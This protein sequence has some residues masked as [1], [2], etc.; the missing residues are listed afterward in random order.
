MTLKNPTDRFADMLR[1]AVIDGGLPPHQTPTP[2]PIDMTPWQ[3][4]SLLQKT[5]RRG[6][7]GFALQAAAS[8]LHLDPDR[9]WRRAGIIAFEDIG[10]ADL[11]TVGMVTAALA[12]KRVRHSLGGEW[13]VA[14]TITQ[15]MAKARKNRAA[16]DLLCLLDSW[17][18]LNDN[19]QR[20]APLLISRLRLIVLTTEL[21]PLRALAL[22]MIIADRRLDPPRRGSTDIA[23][24]ILDELGVAP[25]TLAIAREGYRRTGEVLA[26]L[27]ALLSLENG[28]KDNLHH[29]QMPPASMIGGLP[30][31]TFDMF[32]REGRSALGK[33]LAKDP[34]L[35]D[36]ARTHLPP[37][38]RVEFL[39]QA[40]FRVESGLCLNRVDG[41]TSDNLR[42]A[43]NRDCMGL[44]PNLAVDLLILMRGAIPALN[45][46]RRDV[47][48]E[49]SD[50]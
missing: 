5:I 35:A 4:M 29:D 39:A 42:D 25:T 46:A 36:W 43:M 30:S 26:P 41:P 16:D 28:V 18:A 8:L 48:K 2:S 37:T 47:M 40:L 50:A 49:A 23:F 14:A 9:F 12:G 21:L 38:G 20:L 19:R 3:A 44:P 22:R 24:D 1:Q 32:T 33:L 17:P 27:V 15:A 6:H 34:A 10:V 45:M 7:S 31:W 13:A 11:N